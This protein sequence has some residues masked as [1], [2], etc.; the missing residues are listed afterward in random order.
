MRNVRLL[1]LLAL[2]AADADV[3][4]DG[5]PD[6]TDPCALFWDADTGCPGPDRDG[7]G[8]PDLADLCPDWPEDDNAYEPVDGCPEP[9]PDED[10]VVGTRDACPLEYG[11][12]DIGC[13]DRDQDRDGVPDSRDACRTAPE[14]VDGTEDGD[15]CPEDV[16]ALPAF[17]RARDVL[18][19]PPAVVADPPADPRRDLDGDGLAGDDDRCPFWA[20][21]DRGCPTPD[22]DR[23]G[24]VDSADACPTAPESWFGIADDDGCPERDG[25]RDGFFD[26]VDRCPTMWGDDDGCPTRDTDNDG[27]E[28]PVDDCPQQPEDFDGLHD[29]DGCPEDD[30]DGDG[31]PDTRDRC[32]LFP[33]K[34]RGCPSADGDGDGIPDAFDACPEDPG[35]ARDGCA[36][37]PEP[38]SDGDALDDGVDLYTFPWP[39][40]KP[41]TTSRFDDFAPSGT[42]LG[43]ADDAL[44]AA[45]DARGYTDRSWWELRDG[46]RT[47][48]AVLI[49]RPEQIAL[50]SSAALPGDQRFTSL[51]SELQEQTML[52]R[53][54][55]VG[56]AIFWPQRHYHRSFAFFLT[57]EEVTWSSERLG[58]VEAAS[59]A[60]EGD[61]QLPGH[62]EDL[63]LEKG[64]LT[65]FVY[66][67]EETVGEPRLLLPSG[68]GEPPS[69]RDQL[70]AARL[71]S[72]LENR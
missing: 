60:S 62:L 68:S 8:I 22:A 48:G 56:Q 63:V 18:V 51:A 16:G 28:D 53:M 57:D 21:D 40:P 46:D 43:D 65:V 44:E 71:L 64:R 4:D 45:L 24:I 50:P 35:D 66:V 38:D 32:P 55:E 58:F 5:H 15:G 70:Q 42:R 2:C 6:G 54:L 34:R 13:P 26:V 72:L 19:R 10:G 67:Y 31:R 9:D 37:P 3:D 23:D 61:P 33:G 39:P 49:T 27:V 59:Y 14:D 69:A 20:G 41:T 52:G 25:D 1:F 30:A 17:E 29:A 12:T 36:P 11:E 47:H 7:D